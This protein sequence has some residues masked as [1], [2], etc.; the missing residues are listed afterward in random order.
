MTFPDRPY[1]E[2]TNT[3]IDLRVNDPT[4]IIGKVLTGYQGWFNTPTDGSN[5]GWNHYQGS[6]GVFEPGT[7]TIDFWPDMS[8]AGTDEKYD[9]SFTKKDL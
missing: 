2:F 1:Q 3:S 8:E 4:S 9:T 5:R 6:G 7:A